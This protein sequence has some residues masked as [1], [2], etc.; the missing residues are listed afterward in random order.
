MGS[1]HARVRLPYYRQIRGRD[2]WGKSWGQDRLEEN[3][4]AVQLEKAQ[5][6]AQTL[7]STTR[8]YT[9]SRKRGYSSSSADLYTLAQE[10]TFQKRGRVGNHHGSHNDSGCCRAMTRRRAARRNGVDVDST[11]GKEGRL[12]QSPSCAELRT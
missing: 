8:A 12:A 4:L 2:V 1:R 9:C 11:L 7:M 3:A 10:F 6:I 5:Q